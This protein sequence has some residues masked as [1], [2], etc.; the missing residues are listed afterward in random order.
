MESSS[1]AGRIQCSEDC[2]RLLDLDL[3][4]IAGTTTSGKDFCVEERGAVQVKGKGD[5]MMA[6]WVEPVSEGV[7]ESA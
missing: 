3:N 7:I 1:E 5:T 2:H 4:D 6:Y